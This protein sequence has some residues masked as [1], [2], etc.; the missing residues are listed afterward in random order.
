MHPKDLRV[1]DVIMHAGRP[2]RI[3]AITSHRDQVHKRL[4]YLEL[5]ADGQRV[6]LTVREGAKIETLAAVP[7][8]QAAET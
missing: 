7:Q 8:Q 6:S 4:Y 1:G 5:T 3:T 2:Y